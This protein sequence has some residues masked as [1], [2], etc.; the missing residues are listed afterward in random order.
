MSNYSLDSILN[1]FFICWFLLFYPCCCCLFPVQIYW[2]V[3]FFTIN[4]QL[5]YIYIMFN[6]FFVSDLVKYFYIIFWNRCHLSAFL[7]FFWLFRY[8]NPKNIQEYEICFYKNV[9]FAV[10]LYKH[11]AFLLKLIGYNQP[12]TLMAT[13]NVPVLLEFSQ[14]VIYQEGSD[15]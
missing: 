13:L 12:T 5:R 2:N 4:I 11:Y 6:S 7:N 15:R 1:Y 10:R 8:N 14:L 9:L 3:D